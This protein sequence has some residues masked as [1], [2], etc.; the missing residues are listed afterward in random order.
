[1]QNGIE[2][3]FP[4]KIIPHALRRCALPYQASSRHLLF[5]AEHDKCGRA[6]TWDGVEIRA[7]VPIMVVAYPLARL[8]V[9]LLSTTFSPL[10]K[11]A[12]RF[13]RA[14]IAQDICCF[15]APPGILAS[16]GTHE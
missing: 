9:M 12:G 3:C 8:D 10:V 2:G 13:L 4:Q 1:M 14:G 6:K 16:R 5:I 15:V 7:F 11:H